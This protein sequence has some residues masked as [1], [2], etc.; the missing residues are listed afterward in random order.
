MKKAVRNLSTIMVLALPL[1]AAAPL[2]ATVLNQTAA[3]QVS[4][5]AMPPA[6]P[7]HFTKVID[8][9]PLMP[10]LQLVEDEDVLFAAPGAGRIAETNAIGPV[11]ID[12]VY[13]F[14]RKSLPH[15]GWRAVDAHTYK[16]ESEQLR[17]DA[18]ANHKITVVKFT[19]KPVS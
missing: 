8:D 6:E 13:K 17:I 12:D 15:L 3:D 4:P 7:P 9:L 19:V 11:D 10:G 18:R 1:L 2:Q 16:R 14:Y 5:T